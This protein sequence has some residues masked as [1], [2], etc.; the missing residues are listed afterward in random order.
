[1]REFMLLGNDGSL[2]LR[3]NGATSSRPYEGW[4]YE[5]VV[6]NGALSARIE[7]YDH[8][9]ERFSQYFESLARDWKGW[10]GSRDYQSL[11]PMLTISSAHNGI[12]RVEFTIELRAAA[13]DHFSWSA[14]C[15]LFVEPGQ[16]EALAAS[17]KKF[18]C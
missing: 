6:T 14:S 12:G 13:K 10:S 18:A 4:K 3:G 9:P 8:M 7:V 15:Q 1:M 2:T 17:A 16:L 11:E 5:A